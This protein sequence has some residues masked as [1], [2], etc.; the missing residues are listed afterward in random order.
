MHE[1][2]LSPLARRRRMIVE[3]IDGCLRM[4]IGFS[5]FVLLANGTEL[6]CRLVE[7]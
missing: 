5:G 6:L 1:R 2:R 4:L 3:V 7:R